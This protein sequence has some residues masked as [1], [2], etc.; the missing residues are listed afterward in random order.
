M[1][2]CI[3]C[4]EHATFKIKDT[5]DYYCQNCAKDNFSDLTVLLRVEEEAQ[6][7]KELL[8]EKTEETT[9]DS[10]ED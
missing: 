10:S 8:K 7:L 5:S 6:R 3:I 4:D 2:K 9:H 1:K